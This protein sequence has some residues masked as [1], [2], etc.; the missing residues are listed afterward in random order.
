[1]HHSEHAAAPPRSDAAIREIARQVRAAFRRPPPDDHTR[2]IL[3]A[4]AELAPADEDRVIAALARLGAP[5]SE[6]PS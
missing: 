4:A 5:V 1:M 6:A 3:S 2:W